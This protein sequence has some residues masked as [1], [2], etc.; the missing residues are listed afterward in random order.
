M[1]SK[2]IIN[3]KPHEILFHEND[4]ADCM[5]IVKSGIIRL[6]RSKKDGQIELA[7]LHSGQLIG[8]MALFDETSHRRTCSA[9][10][11][12][13][14]EL[15]RVT[16]DSF[17]S[18]FKQLNPWFQTIINT[19]VARLID[20]NAQVTKF[21]DNSVTLSY[22]KGKVNSFTFFKEADIARLFT[23]F[24]L[25]VKDKEKENRADV[26][27]KAIEYYVEEVF[28]ISASRFHEFVE[29]M[30]DLGI[31]NLVK[32]SEGELSNIHIEDIALLKRSLIYFNR[33][34]Q[35]VDEKKIHLTKNC[36]ELL[37][38]ILDKHKAVP[39]NVEKPNVNIQ[40]I[41]EDF[42]KRGIVLG[43]E[44][45]GNAIKHGIL[46]EPFLDKENNT[47]CR[48]DIGKV[49]QLLPVLRIGN[50]FDSLNSRKRTA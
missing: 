38:R 35:L 33:E 34:R 15:A 12:T 4:T 7:I 14:T 43:G 32:D 42:R 18:I 41:L 1:T 21:E 13:S 27:K 25:A 20:S 23:L 30:I 9:E 50:A 48:V 17:H 31:V 16:Y 45:Y 10:S 36:I 5:Y 19:L 28:N 37:E 26:N 8:E 3:L 6:F 39:Y 24:Y 46:D 40:G 22:G 29:V 49:I 2:E 44:D 47:I 11:I